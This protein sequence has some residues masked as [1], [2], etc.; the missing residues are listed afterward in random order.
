MTARADRSA[1]LGD[2]W[3]SITSLILG[4]ASVVMAMAFG[5]G[6]VVGVLAVAFGGRSLYES[7]TMG[8]RPNIKAISGILLGIVGIVIFI[9]T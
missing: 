1:R 3:K 4:V 5:L 9:A 8:A 2:N 7:S 6:V